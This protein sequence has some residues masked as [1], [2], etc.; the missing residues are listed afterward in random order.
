MDLGTGSHHHT[1]TD[2]VER[3]RSKTGRGGDD[4]SE[5]ERGEDVAL[6]GT[7]EDDGLDGVVETKVETTVDDDTNDGGN[8]ATVETGNTVGSEGLLVD[9]NETVELTRA[10]LGG[11]LVVV[12]KTGTGVVERVDEEEG[13]GT[14]GTTRGNV[15]SEPLPVAVRLLEA[16]EGLEV[17]LEGKV[18]GLGGEVTDDVGSVTTPEG[19]KTLL[20]VDTREAVSNALVGLGE[21]AL[22]DP[23]GQQIFRLWEEKNSHLVLVLDE[24][25]DTLDGGSGSLGDGGGHTSHEEVGSER[26]EVLWLLDLRHFCCGLVLRQ[27]SGSWLGECDE[28]GAATEAAISQQQ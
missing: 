9:V 28:G 14:G 10:A 19:G 17:V 12:G 15:T 23:K 6:E 27:A 18:E 8:E 1:T 21:T 2:G 16:K 5:S 13:R 24:E 22:L 26:L 3:V 4:P 25:L 7:D 20:G 11:R